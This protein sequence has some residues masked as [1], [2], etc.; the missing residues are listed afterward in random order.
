MSG[1]Q[2][3]NEDSLLSNIDAMLGDDVDDAPTESESTSDTETQQSAESAEAPTDQQSNT[4]TQP[5]TGTADRPAQQY[6]EVRPG[7]RIDTRKLPA[8]AS[9]NLVD[10]KSG[11]IVA[12]AG[13]ERAYF[14]QARNTFRDLERTRNDYGAMQRELEAYKSAAIMPTQL[15]LAP[16][17]T[18]IALQFMAKYINDPQAAARDLLTDMQAKGYTIEEIGRG[19]D[20]AAMKAM[21]EN[22]VKPFVDDRQ[23]VLKQEQ[24]SKRIE[25]EWD[26]VESRHPWLG[27]QDEALSKIMIE[28]DLS[29]KD[30]ALELKVWALEH[31]YDLNRSVME[32]IAEQGQAQQQAPVQQ[33]PAQPQR[34]NRAQSVPPSVADGAMPLMPRNGAQTAN[35]NNTKDIIRDSMKQFGFRFE[36]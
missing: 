11:K 3:I 8:D 34:M 16:A 17:E 10:P 33:A 4:A 7:A 2:D 28:A 19:T 5:D 25:Q 1:T 12:R 21:I 30:A 27:N 6:A 9:G 14:E 29:L 15:G 24:E 18:A 36:R 35:R 32:Q 31:G 13:T 22:A 26:D 20:A 23:S